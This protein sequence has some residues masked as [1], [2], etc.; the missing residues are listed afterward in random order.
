M[1]RLPGYREDKLRIEIS[2]IIE[3][4]EILE[5]AETS[6]IVE[7]GMSLSGRNLRYIINKAKVILPLNCRLV[8]LVFL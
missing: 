3:I 2:G 6:G 4:S 1:R 7:I 5:T 8:Y